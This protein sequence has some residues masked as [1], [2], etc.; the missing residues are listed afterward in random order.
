MHIDIYCSSS[1]KRLL[2]DE[3]DCVQIQGFII[4]HS[5]CPSINGKGYDFFI[6]AD[7][8]V[9]AAAEMTDPEYIHLCFEGDFATGPVYLSSEL[10]EQFFVAKKLIIGIAEIYEISPHQVFSHSDMCPG[11]YFP[12]KE[13]VISSLDG[14]H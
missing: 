1:V 7:G 10:K 11:A 8:S 12:W 3:V 9:I 5:V 13:L 2:E 6:A 4:H 14:Y